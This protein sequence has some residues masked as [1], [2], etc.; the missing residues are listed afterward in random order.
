MLRSRPRLLPWRAR[1]TR[2]RYNPFLRQSR[3]KQRRPAAWCST[4]A[5]LRPVP[6]AMLGAA[7]SV[8]KQPQACTETVV[9]SSTTES[10]VKVTAQQPPARP[11]TR[12]QLLLL[13][14]AVAIG[15]GIA[16]IL[17]GTSS[18]PLGTTSTNSTGVTES[19]V[20]FTLR[21]AGSVSD[22]TMEVRAGL[23]SAFASEIGLTASAVTVDIMAGSVIITVS[24]V[25]PVVRTESIT[26]QL[27]TI[28][29]HPSESGGRD[30]LPRG[31]RYQRLRHRR[32]RDPC[33]S[34]RSGFRRRGRLER[35][36]H[37]ALVTSPGCSSR[38]RGHVALITPRGRFAQGMATVMCPS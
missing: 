30:R 32:D 2:S 23:A 4:L 35:R 29:N 7:S 25:T 8:T 16:A 33:G 6:T 22:Y 38:R 17:I 5:N 13:T 19:S 10:E 3:S 31:G 15:G 27:Q 12:R 11:K 20:I 9:V 14:L 34:P 1:A 26:S 28:P 24:I 21:A 18:A 37:V 36:G